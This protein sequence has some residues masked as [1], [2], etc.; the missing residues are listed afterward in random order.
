MKR[1]E[2]KGTCASEI[3]MAGTRVFKKIYL[4][5]NIDANAIKDGVRILEELY[6]DQI[7]KPLQIDITEKLENQYNQLIFSYEQELLTPWINDSWISSHKLHK[8]GQI[9]LMQQSAL[10]SHGLTFVDARPSNY[11]LTGTFRLVDLGSIKPLQEYALESFINDFNNHFIKPLLLEKKLG[12]PVNKFYKGGLQTCEID[13]LKIVSTL[14]KPDL[15]KAGLKDWLNIFVSK[16]LAKSSTQFIS[17]ITSKIAQ[18]NEI[19]TKRASRKTRKLDRLLKIVEPNLAT[20]TI[21]ANYQCFH[22][23]IYMSNKRKAVES[24]LSTESKESLIVDL[25][26]NTTNLGDFRSNSICFV[27]SDMAICNYLER[28]MKRNDLV[29]CTDI[30]EELVNLQENAKSA[31]NADGNAD[32][33]I[34]IGI[35]HHIAISGGISTEC[36]CSGFA[37]VYKKILLEFIE[38]EDPMLQFLFYKKKESIP[39]EWEQQKKIWGKNFKISQPKRLS[40]TRFYVIL[41]RL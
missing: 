36:I 33:A 15:I 10:V 22:D 23:S 17:Y 40:K 28:N 18:S 39:W 19:P 7:S 38:K 13:T 21:W 31:L 1:I 20:E 16:Q 3:K 14:R 2:K 26:S 9:I 5:N 8:L 34:A 35:I 4:D 37:T 27:D 11:Q 30:A 24:F 25:G 12:I 32:K 6:P 41:E 29:I